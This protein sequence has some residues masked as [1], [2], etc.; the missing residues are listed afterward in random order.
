MSIST[1]F[2]IIAVVFAIFA[3][4]I[5]LGYPEGRTHKEFRRIDKSRRRGRDGRMGG[6]RAGDRL[7]A[8]RHNSRLRA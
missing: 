4:S 2:G 6:R 7:A 1:I 5:R 3:F 8:T